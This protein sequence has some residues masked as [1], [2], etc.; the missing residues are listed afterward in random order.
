MSALRR[1]RRYRLA[2]PASASSNG[3]A[4]PSA[5]GNHRFGADSPGVV[6]P[7]RHSDGAT[8]AGLVD[9]VPVSRSVPS[10]YCCQRAP[11]WG[12]GVRS[13]ACAAAGAAARQAT[14]RQAIQAR[15]RRS[16]R[17]FP[18]E[19]ASCQAQYDQ[20]AG[21]LTAERAAGG[22]P[23]RFGSESAFC[24]L[25]PSHHSWLHPVRLPARASH[26][27]LA[28]FL[29]AYVLSNSLTRVAPLTS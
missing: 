21:C 4:A 13:A 17:S 23:F 12:V 11:G 10:G 6:R 22:S 9:V 3:A 19:K 26:I 15:I 28:R 8:G 24:C 27:T 29:K 16:S 5:I 7:P 20:G 1:K 25:S 2:P 14:T 18:G